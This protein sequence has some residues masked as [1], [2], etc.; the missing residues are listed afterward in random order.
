MLEQESTQA[1]GETERDIERDRDTWKIDNFLCPPITFLYLLSFYR[2][3]IKLYYY[4]FT[5]S[6]PM[7]CQSALLWKHGLRWL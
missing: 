6:N 4:F 3:I 2:Y 7:M 1:K 5:Y